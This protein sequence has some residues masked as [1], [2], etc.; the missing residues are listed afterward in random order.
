MKYKAIITDL[1]RTL[2]RTDKSVSR[3]TLS[4]FRRCKE[5]GALLL[6]ATARPHRSIHEYEQLLC[7]DG[8]V[9][10]NGAYV[11]R[12]G[13]KTEH[14]IDIKEAERFLAQV[15]ADFMPTISA[16]SDG[17][18]YANTVFEEWESVYWDKFPELPKGALHKILISY[19]GEMHELVK[20]YLP[21]SMYCTVAAGK[22]LQIMSEE[23]TK[24][25]GV[26]SLLKMFDISLENAVYFGDDYDDIEPVKQCGLGVAMANGI[27]D[28]KRCADIITDTNDNDGVAL[29]LERLLNGEAL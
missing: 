23:A 22:L 16:E 14:C 29:I 28:I 6:A 24:I 9:C 13:I 15:C 3:R 17:I 7:F 11:C 4:A 5:A 27:D 2:L 25:N 12:N 18:L 20:R 8:V 26:L 10:L 19:S 1:D 21:P